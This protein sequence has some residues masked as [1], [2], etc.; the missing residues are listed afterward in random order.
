MDGVCRVTVQ[1]GGRRLDV[2]LPAD[3]PLA[4]LL[5]AVVAG[6]GGRLAERAGEG[7]ALHRLAGPALDSAHTATQLGVRHGEVLQ[8][9]PLWTDAPVLRVDDVVDAIGT[10]ARDLPGRW[11]PGAARA[12]GLAWLGTA[13]AA[14]LVPVVS[15]AR[16][17]P[18]PSLVS[19]GIAAVLLAGAAIAGRG[20]GGTDLGA[21]LGLGAVGYAF[22]AGLSLFAGHPAASFDALPGWAVGCAAA[23]AVAVLAG[24]LVPARMPEL[25]GAAALAGCGLAGTGVAA[26]VHANLAGAAAAALA[27]GLLAAGLVPMFAFRLSRLPMPFVPGDR[28]QLADGGAEVR[29]AEIA[30]GTARADRIVTALVAAGAGLA[31][32]AAPAVLARPGWAGPTLTGTA[33]LAL[34]LRARHHRGLAQRL[35]LHGSALA[36]LVGTAIGVTVHSRQSL[37][38]VGGLLGVAV[39]AALAVPGA[40]SARRWPP[41][42]GRLGDILELLAVVALLPLALQLLGV[43]AQVR[44]LGG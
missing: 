33:A 9:R 5:P 27:L 34:V 37:L 32:L 35:W 13:L 12:C 19:F 2:G 20:A 22:T 43:Y 8:L 23:L 41:T 1:V 18:V 21:L 24:T 3:V 44:Q 17:W 31:V 26:A 29:P 28:P 38:V 4:E 36:L 6:A 14:G 16:L 7:W 40:G 42:V 25:T 11:S 15:G 30:A 39:L 10:A